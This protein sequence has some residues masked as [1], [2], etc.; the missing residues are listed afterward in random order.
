MTSRGESM[1]VPHGAASTCPGQRAKRTG[2]VHRY[3]SEDQC[4]RPRERTR[5]IKQRLSCLI[6][7]DV[8]LISPAPDPCRRLTQISVHASLRVD[9]TTYFSL[10]WRC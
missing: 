2:I 7:Q 5:S 6:G 4:L 10:A 8:D 3:N 1:L 9:G